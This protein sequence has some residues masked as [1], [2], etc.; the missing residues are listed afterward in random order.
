VTR[1]LGWSLLHFVWQGTAVAG[2]VAGLDLLLR[3]ASAQARYLV[4][5][6]GLLAMLVLPALTF[7]LLVTSAPGAGPIATTAPGPLA[8][9]GPAAVAPARADGPARLGAVPLSRR[10][11][12]LL[13]VLVG[14]WGIGVL[15]LSSR[16]LGGLVLLRRLRRS[17]LRPAPA[18]LVAT[19][20]RIGSAL[21][22]RARVRVFESALVK[23]PTVVGWL[24]PAILVPA[25]ALA[26]LSP[27]QLELILAHELAHVRRGDYLVNLVQAAVETLL[28][29]HP[30]VWWVSN[31]V[32][33][34]REH[35]CDD[36]AVV[37][38][39]SP[40]RY[41][42][43]LT[44][45]GGLCADAPAL[46]VAAT[47][48]SLLDRVARL[49]GRAPEPSPA[50]R[51]AAALVAVAAMLLALGLG[52][53]LLDRPGPVVGRVSASFSAVEPRPV[54]S[55]APQA[56]E[57][58]V[59]SAE[60][61]P[62]VGKTPTPRAADSPPQRAFPLPRVIEMAR[63]G[64]TPEFVDEM[65]AAGYASL[66]ADELIALRQQGVGP[67]YVRELAASGS[68]GLP[69]EEL[70]SLRAQGVS[71]RYARA[72]A[73]QG[74]EH[75]SVSDLLALRGQG[76]GPDLVAELKNAGDADLSVT[77]LIALRSQGVGA[78]YVAE[79]QALGY[80]GL[81]TQTLLALR[82]Q[83]VGP[84]YVRGLADLGYRGLDPKR[85]I[86]LRSQGVTPDYVRGLKDGGYTGLSPETLIELRSE[87][88][89]PDYVAGLAAQ[90]LTGLTAQTLVRLR[91]QGVTPDYVRDL[92]EAGFTDL[93]AE[94]LVQLRSQGVSAAQL[95]RRRGRK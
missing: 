65:A 58:P 69:V 31:R 1:A 66:S 54:P 4:A 84:D 27:Q 38:C 33:I 56:E 92:R 15:V 70:M 77:S 25:S 34:E 16:A 83:G 28:F 88:V 5:C 26:G 51:L 9:A 89:S 20:R 43:A 48:G 82:S 39:G 44:D 68:R 12:P 47:G 61:K 18:G 87:G 59:A 64:V 7:R 37:L 17:Q 45:L 50:G 74:L 79:L 11:D 29:Y 90:G 14:G 93:T 63:A 67:D 62:A 52:S 78:R 22:L 3:R 76:V 86:A 19:V 95:K 13:P 21:R 75:L 73:E 36:V 85:L 53:V 42:R 46:G 6:A 91:S 55:A 60:S 23:V 81:S 94:E 72:L 41:A 8:G 49:L 2:L 71:A 80:D 57:P 10:I 32:R 30:A 24:R 40:L 35:C